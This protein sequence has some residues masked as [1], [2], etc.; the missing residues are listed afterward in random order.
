MNE[1]MF[2][3]PNLPARTSYMS[4]AHSSISGCLLTALLSAPGVKSN[5]WLPNARRVSVSCEPLM[6]KST[7]VR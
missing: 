5:C 7:T 2:S 1:R 3:S 6:M 4:F